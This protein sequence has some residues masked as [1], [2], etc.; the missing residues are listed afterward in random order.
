VEQAGPDGEKRYIL[1]LQT[2][3]DPSGVVWL[4]LSVYARIGAY[5]IKQEWWL[6]NSGVIRARVGSKGLSCN[7]DHYHHP[8]WRFHFQLGDQFPHRVDLFTQ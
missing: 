7:I 8:Y 5:H 2:D 3:P 1:I 4:F 6:N